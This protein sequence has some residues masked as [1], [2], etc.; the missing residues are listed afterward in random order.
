MVKDCLTNCISYTYRFLVANCDEVYQRE[1][2]NHHQLNDDEPLISS[3]VKTT[4]HVNGPSL[5][6][7][8]FWHQL[9]YLLTWTISEDQEQYSL[10]LNQ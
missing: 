8:K 3:T 4:T 1:S 10:V 7:L 9:I 6:S 2:K 5:K